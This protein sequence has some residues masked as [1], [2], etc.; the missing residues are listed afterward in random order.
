MV[1]LSS[2]GTNPMG[3]GLLRQLFCDGHFTVELKQERPQET[4]LSNAEL[5]RKGDLFGGSKAFANP[6]DALRHGG[7]QYCRSDPD[8]ERCLRQEIATVDAGRARGRE[9]E[10]VRSS[11]RLSLSWTS[12]DHCPHRCH[13]CSKMQLVWTSLEGEADPMLQQALQ[14]RSSTLQSPLQ[15]CVNKH[16]RPPPCPLSAPSVPCPLSFGQARTWLPWFK[17]CLVSGKEEED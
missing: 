16:S 14:V 17:T 3:S 9:E 8:V 4:D 2:R 11:Q 10:A 7:L 13:L 12:G 5:G 15:C 1:I 6:E